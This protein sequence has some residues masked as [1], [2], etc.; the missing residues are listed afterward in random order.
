MAVKLA[1]P[2][3]HGCGRSF[4]YPHSYALHAKHCDGTKPKT[5]GAIAARERASAKRP[6]RSEPPR[7]KKG[8]RTSVK[9]RSR[10]GGRL[11]VRITADASQAV[12]ELGRMKKA[13]AQAITPAAFIAALEAEKAKIDR[14]IAAVRELA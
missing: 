7:A 10:K 8:A 9:R 6:V 3:V 12:R 1:E 4:D 11:H 14:A 5:E 13:V 2:M